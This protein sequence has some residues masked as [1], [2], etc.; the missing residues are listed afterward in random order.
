MVRFPMTIYGYHLQ[1][2]NKEYVSALTQLVPGKAKLL[3]KKN[4]PTQL[5][6]HCT[7]DARCLLQ[8]LDGKE[9]QGRGGGGGGD[10][11]MDKVTP[12]ITSSPL[13]LPLPPPITSSPLTLP[14]PPH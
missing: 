13:P 4:L 8:L 9:G 3:E 5:T 2:P 1:Y 10:G 12:H 14:L 7:D 11:V 6:V